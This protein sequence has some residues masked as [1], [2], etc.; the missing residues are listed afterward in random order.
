[1]GERA[2]GSVKESALHSPVFERALQRFLQHLTLDRGLSKNTV[3]AY[4]RDVLGYLH[5]L[6]RRGVGEFETVDRVTVQDFVADLTGL[7]VTTVSRK[8]SCL[9]NFHGFLYEEKITEQN[10]CSRLR[11]P[12][13]GLYLPHA[14][15]VSEVEKLL[16]SCSQDSAGKLRDR[17]FLELM[18][19]TGA[20]VSE[21]L[22]LNLD[23]L[24]EV[25]NND[26]VK[27][28]RLFGKGAK[29]RIVPYGK[30]AAD[31]LDAY[32]VRARP[33]L[34]S[35]TGSA[36]IFVNA[37]GGR[38]TRQ[39]AWTI[40]KSAAARAHLN[41][42]ISPHSL[43]HSFATHML[44][45]G[46]DVR[47]VQELLGHASVTTTQIYTRITQDTLREHYIQAHPRSR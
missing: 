28:L 21:L 47:T 29:E 46:A 13:K 5:W 41:T 14:L 15:T 11:A 16:E 19:A 32:L 33:Q 4:S 25:E 31:A 39:G 6:E 9:R 24:L 34:A 22:Q 2:K 27:F 23:D 17:A 1:M 36:A 20:R 40:V 18:Y 35:T 10:P 3:Q 44:T 37:R 45:G 30:H 26:R 42:K 12:K 38:L 7:K 8:I 43:R